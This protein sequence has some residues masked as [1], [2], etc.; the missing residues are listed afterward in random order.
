MENIKIFDPIELPTDQNELNLYGLTEIAY[1]AHF[2]SNANLEI[3]I[4]TNT[5]NIISE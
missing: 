5:Q 2:Y 1:F 3:Q 4:L